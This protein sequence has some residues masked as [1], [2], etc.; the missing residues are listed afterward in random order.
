MSEPK[1]HRYRWAGQISDDEWC[2][3]LAGEPMYGRIPPPLPP[4]DFQL[5]W[6]GATGVATFREAMAFCQRLKSV[7]AASGDG[8]TAESRLLDIGVG[9]GRLYRVLMRDTPNIIGI[10]PGSSLHRTLPYNA[11]RS[12][13]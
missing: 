13:G 8:L 12:A 1:Q 7:M 5:A 3:F 10:G 4:D 11:S 9:W 2:R 6:T